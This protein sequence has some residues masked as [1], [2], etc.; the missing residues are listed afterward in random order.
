MAAYPSNKQE[1]DFLSGKTKSA[2][3]SLS[4]RGGAGE[5]KCDGKCSLTQDVGVEDRQSA[6][7]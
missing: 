4:W 3:D 1:F 7:V 6:A 5:G 2:S